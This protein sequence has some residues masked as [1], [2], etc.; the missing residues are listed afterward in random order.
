MKGRYQTSLDEK[1]I[2]NLVAGLFG[3]SQNIQNEFGSI[4]LMVQKSG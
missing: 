3:I 4:V 2:R 1:K